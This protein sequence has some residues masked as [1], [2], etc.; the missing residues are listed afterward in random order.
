MRILITNDDGILGEGLKIL[1][2]WAKTKGEVTICAPLVEQSGKSQGIEIHKAFEVKPYDY[3]E[4]VR[5]FTV[6]STPA[7][8]VRF[9]LLGLEEKFDLVLSGINKGF[10]MGGDIVYSGTVGAACE[11]AGLGTP[12]IAISTDYRSFDS[13]KENIKRVMDFIFEK[14]LL[15]IHNLYNVNIPLEADTIRFTQQ[16][17]AYFTDSFP[18]IG[19]DM[20]LPTGRCIH[21]NKGNL[22]LDTDCTICGHVSISPLSLVRTDCKAFESL[23]KIK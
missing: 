15:E 17:G 1:C 3:D 10:N 20:Y 11:A 13:A 6:D 2:D 16:G 14:N 22:E 21:D 4:G 19:N 23:K 9:A 18:P 5:A 8:C 7:D 12:A